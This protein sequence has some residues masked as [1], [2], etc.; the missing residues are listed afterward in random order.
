MLTLLPVPAFDDNYLWLVWGQDPRR[1]IAVDPG[2]AAPVAAALAARGAELVAI[3][4]THHHGDHIGGVAE[5]AASAR[6]Q[7]RAAGSIPV[8]GPR[9]EAQEVVTHPLDDG[10]AVEVEEIGAHFEVMAVPGHTRGHIAFL[11]RD[12]GAPTLFCG[13]TLFSAGCGRLFEGTAEQMAASLDRLAELPAATRVCC[14]H[15]Y[16][17]ANLA[18]AA[19]VEPG[20]PAV[21]EYA[22]AAAAARG[23]GEPTLPSTIGLERQVNPF[24]R[25]EVPEV[26][27]AAARWSGSQPAGRVAVFAALRRW[28]DGFR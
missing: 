24:L 7:G 12:P 5:L 10:E 11:H 8:Y 14:A 28:K 13:D 25:T 2:S 15:E 26:A 19:A 20:N 6:P 22:R 21:A 9:G 23:R 18:F 16:T 3:L 4:V 1:A 17:L 27:A